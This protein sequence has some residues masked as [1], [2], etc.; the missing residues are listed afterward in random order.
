MVEFAEPTH[1]NAFDI[2]RQLLAARIGEVDANWRKSSEV[3]LAKHNGAYLFGMFDGLAIAASI[4]ENEPHEAV[5][6]KM[7]R[8]M[9]V[10]ANF[11]QTTKFTEK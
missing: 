1:E 9:I 6:D 7:L 11:I 3:N 4:V 5:T 8:Q 2:L 10:L